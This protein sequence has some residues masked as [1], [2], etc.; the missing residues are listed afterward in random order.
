MCCRS[1]TDVA[2]SNVAKSDAQS[3]C[4]F[5]SVNS[6]RVGLAMVIQGNTVLQIEQNNDLSSLMLDKF[7]QPNHSASELDMLPAALNLEVG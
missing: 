7:K 6:H 4:I 5:G 1:N 2:E 3:P